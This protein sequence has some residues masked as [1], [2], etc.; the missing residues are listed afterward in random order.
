MAASKSLLHEFDP[1]SSGP[2]P[3]SNLPSPIHP[4]QHK[5]GDLS[6]SNVDGGGDGFVSGEEGEQFLY[7][8][9]LLRALDVSQRA[10]FKVPRSPA[11]PGEGLKMRPLSTGDY[12]KGTCT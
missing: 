3:A 12:Q 5:M 7:D 9:S 4:E 2:G 1:F 11:E 10:T 6:I 8:S